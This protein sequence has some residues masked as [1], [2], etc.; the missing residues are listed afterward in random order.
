LLGI[1]A[2]RDGIDSVYAWSAAAALIAIP[3][4]MASGRTLQPASTPD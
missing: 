4:A 3:F 1:V 2:A